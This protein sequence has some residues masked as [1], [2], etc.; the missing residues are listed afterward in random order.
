MRSA[1]VGWP[2][3]PAVRCLLPHRLRAQWWGGGGQSVWEG[4]Q[5]SRLLAPFHSSPM[6]P[7][8]PGS[9]PTSLDSE[10]HH[11]GGQ[12]PSCLPLLLLSPL[13][14]SGQSPG[15]RTRLSLLQAARQ[16][17]IQ[18]FGPPAP[19]Q[20]RRNAGILASTSLH[21][22][23]PSK[24]QARTQVSKSLTSP[25]RPHS[26]ARTKASRPTTPLGSSQSPG[27]W[28]PKIRHSPPP[29]Q[30]GQNSGRVG[31]QVSGQGGVLTGQTGLHVGREQETR[32]LH[33]SGGGQAVGRQ[34]SGTGLHSHGLHDAAG[35][36]GG[37]RQPNSRGRGWAWLQ[38][39]TGHGR[40][41][42]RRPRCRRCQ[43]GGHGH[44]CGKHCG[45]KS[46]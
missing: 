23:D 18:A 6:E 39:R 2:A 36:Q 9:Q 24:N 30:S 43:L 44:R 29:L 3:K 37:T 20:A 13:N 42:H 7:R 17:G 19:P 16:E 21:P 34:R 4:T 11:A 25:R 14:Q 8:H 38:G 15:A 12:N 33:R 5:A 10:S 32:R 22:A 31:T 46:T 35:P 40:G 45:D 27:A 28:P 1:G 26:E 41:C